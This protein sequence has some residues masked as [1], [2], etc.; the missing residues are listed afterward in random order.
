MTMPQPGHNSRKKKSRPVRA[1]HV[2]VRTCISCRESGAKRGLTRIVR[3]PE[4]TVQIDPTG[5][6]N[7]R[8]AYLCE[9]PE[10]WE[11]ATTTPILNRALNTQLTP[12]TLQT[13]MEFAAGLSSDDG[14]RDAGAD[15]EE[16]A[17]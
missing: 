3:S 2:P 16:R 10:C 12:E 11:R 6:M 15:S 4:G 14:A 13:L 17:T 7:G 8:G 5:R 1:K 9:K